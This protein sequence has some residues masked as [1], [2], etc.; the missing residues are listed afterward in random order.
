MQAMLSII[1]KGDKSEGKSSSIDFSLN[2]FVE[3][4]P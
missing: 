3:F 4:F 2:E 1:I